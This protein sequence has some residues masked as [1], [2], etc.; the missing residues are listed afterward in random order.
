MSQLSEI[1][2]R[3]TAL[4]TS[5]DLNW[6]NH[7]KA[8]S[9]HWE[10][11][12]ETLGELKGYIKQTPERKEVCMKQS[13]DYTHTVVGWVLGIPIAIVSIVAVIAELHKLFSH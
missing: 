13:K 6:K 5:N 10:S 11:I 12:K 2:E 1:N 4:E 7:D 3:L 8:S 9:E